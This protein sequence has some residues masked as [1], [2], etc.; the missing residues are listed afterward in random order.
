[1]TGGEMIWGVGLQSAGEAQLWRAAGA[2][3]HTG[4]GNS[5]ATAAMRRCSAAPISFSAT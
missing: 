3:R 2:V 5:L 4:H 1:M